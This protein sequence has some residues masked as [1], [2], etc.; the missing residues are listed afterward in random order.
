MLSGVSPGAGK[1]SVLAQL[2]SQVPPPVVRITEDDV[3]GRRET[4]ESPVDRLSGREDFR[5]LVF[6][7]PDGDSAARIMQLFAQLV[8]E[9]VAAKSLW[10][11]DWTWPELIR[12]SLEL[13][14]EQEVGQTSAQVRALA[15]PVRPLIVHLDLDPQVAVQ[16]ALQE[17]G[18]IWFNRH[19]GRSLH[20][21]V[22]VE[23]IR[24]GA[25]RYRSTSEAKLDAL[26]AAGWQV[27]R[28]DAQR[29]LADV[30]SDTLLLVQ[31][32]T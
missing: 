30:V 6:R 4:G 26:S 22:Q 32:A 15:E 8:D 1:S 20:A 21:P 14:T 5:R 12:M 16:R 10:L 29:A 27:R 31:P 28:V 11:Q 13:P 9:C 2:A 3:W 19:F 7:P 17:R 24:A 23:D 25:A 18:D